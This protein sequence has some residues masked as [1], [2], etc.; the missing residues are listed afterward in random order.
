LG[1]ASW[2]ASEAI[3]VQLELGAVLPLVRYELGADTGTAIFRTAAVGLEAGLGAAW[4][5]P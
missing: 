3:S 4:R 1:R 2:L 5:L